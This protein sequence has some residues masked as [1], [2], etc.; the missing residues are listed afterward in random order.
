MS[1]IMDA[2]P[3]S[4]QMIERTLRAVTMG[5]KTTTLDQTETPMPT[6]DHLATFP[7]KGTALPVRLRTLLS[8]IGLA[9]L[10]QVEVTSDLEFD[11][12]GANA[13]YVHMLVAVVPESVDSPVPILDE[14]GHGVVSFSVPA[15]GRKGASEKFSPSMSGYDYIVASWGD[16]SYFTYNLAEKVW[17]ALG[18]SPRC[19][20]NEQQRIVYDDLGVPEFAVAEGEAAREYH[21]SSSRNVSW[22]MSDPARRGAPARLAETLQE[23]IEEPSE[24]AHRFIRYLESQKKTHTFSTKRG[25]KNAV[26][27]TAIKYYIPLG[28][29]LSHL[30]AIGSNLKKLID[31]KITDKRLEDLAPSISVTDLECV[32]ELLP[33]EAEKIHYF[34]RRREFEA[35]MGYEGDELDLLGFYL[36]TGFN[37]GK[38]EYDKDTVI[39]MLLK[40]KELDPYFIGS[41]EGKAIAKPFLSMT[42]WWRDILNRISETRH[43][44]WIETAF[45][46]LNTTKEDQEKFE[47]NFKILVHRINRGNVDKAHNF[48]VWKSGPDRRQY[49][50]VGYPYTTSDRE[51]RNSVIG[52]LIQGD[53]GVGAR[54]IAVIGVDLSSSDYPYSVLA[55]KASTDLFDTLTI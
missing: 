12:D 38:T 3:H 16:G 11:N 54:G 53:L 5:K 34:A 45:I 31:A 26:D 4:R 27:S 22:R 15:L 36:D 25:T 46:L 41:R 28:V 51:V 35:H 32:L 14:A 48:V 47:R 30:G 1:A 2:V 49:V 42:T 18:L 19:L 13:E 10:E 20:G 33:L 17:M 24:Q 21:F 8:P 39:N 6:I 52:D 40:S 23:L 44:G 9:P 55:R 29:T 7:I 43:E 50:I 37:I